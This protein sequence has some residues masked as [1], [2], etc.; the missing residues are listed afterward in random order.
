MPEGRTLLTINIGAFGDKNKSI[1]LFEHI[2][3]NLSRTEQIA[4]APALQWGGPAVGPLR[5]QE[6]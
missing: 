6:P 5:G 2:L 1:V 4:A 3:D